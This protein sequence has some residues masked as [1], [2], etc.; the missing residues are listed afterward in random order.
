MEILGETITFDEGYLQR[1][2]VANATASSVAYHRTLEMVNK[3]LFKR[4]LDLK[5][6]VQTFESVDGEL[7]YTQEAIDKDLTTGILAACLASV[8]VTENS[9]RKALHAHSVTW[10]ASSP[11][12][13][14]Q[15]AADEEIWVNMAEAL[16]SQ[17]QGEV[18]VEVHLIKGLSSVLKVRGPRATFHRESYVDKKDSAMSADVKAVD[19]GVLTL[20]SNWH[21]HKFTCHHGISGQHG[22]RFAK[23]QGIR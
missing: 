10:T 12:F 17:I 14:A 1:C 19:E 3:I 2:V 20:S 18:G 9:K 16:E 22:C 23:K 11:A 13:L 7:R 4:P 21:D 5:K 8:G 15:I 6:S